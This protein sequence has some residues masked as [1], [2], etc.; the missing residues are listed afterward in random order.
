VVAAVATKV[1]FQI[2]KLVALVV[3]QHL[4][5]LVLV[6][7][8]VMV[9]VLLAVQQRPTLVQAAVELVVVLQLIVQLV[10]GVVLADTSRL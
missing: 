10:P 5:D 1:L 9:L 7:M 4:V 3:L 6:D 2:S 8:V